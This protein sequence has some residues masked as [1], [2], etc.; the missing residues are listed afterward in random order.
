MK[1]NEIQRFDTI[2]DNIPS[3]NWADTENLVQSRAYEKIK[4]VGNLDN[5]MKIMLR[6]SDRHG[7][8]IYLLNNESPIERIGV[9]SL[10]LHHH[11]YSIGSTIATNYQGQNLGY[12]VYK[13]LIKN[14]GYTL[15][16]GET[17]SFG[18]SYVWTKLWE[19]PG[20]F[21]YGAI[22]NPEGPNEYFEVEPDEIN[23]RL[24]SGK[25]DVYNDYNY[26]ESFSNQTAKLNLFKY[27]DLINDMIA[28]KEIKPK[29][30]DKLMKKYKKN[31]ENELNA[32]INSGEYTHLIAVKE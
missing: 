3:F 28:K 24:L 6:S 8:T 16:S 15:V 11:G 5:G 14:L 4:H 2:K 9:F 20:I 10:A 22:E 26:P 29:D 19:T 13:F 25:H 12:Q 27:R 32:F 31:Y 7:K 23:P 21:V 18:S 30:G 17:Q 1:I